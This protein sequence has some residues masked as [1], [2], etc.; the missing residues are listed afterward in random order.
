MGMAF[1]L[2]TITKWFNTDNKTPR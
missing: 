2:N 1:A